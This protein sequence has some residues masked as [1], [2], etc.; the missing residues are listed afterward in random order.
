MGLLA[1]EGWG[2]MLL[3]GGLLLWG[4]GMAGAGGLSVAGH[5]VMVIHMYTN[6]RLS[7]N[8]RWGS[9]LLRLFG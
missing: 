1:S 2:G 4:L 5:L 3:V 7:P 9:S 8:L 6:S